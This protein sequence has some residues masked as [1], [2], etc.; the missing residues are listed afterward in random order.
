[1][2]SVNHP[3][4]EIAMRTK[5]CPALLMALGLLIALTAGHEP[6]AGA[7]MTVRQRI[8][9]LVQPYMESQ[10]VVGMTI[11]VWQNDQETFLGYGHLGKDDQRLPDGDTVYEIGSVSKVFTGVLLADAVVREHVRLDQPAGELL[12]PDVAMP[13]HAAR[14]ITLQD[15]STHVSGLPRLPN[16]LKVADPA[17]P[18]A[19]YSAD[20]LFA[21]LKA[22]TVRRAPGERSEYSNVAVGLLGQLLAR[23]QACTYEELLNKR[24]VAPLGMTS[25][26]ITLDAQQTARLATPHR[27][28]GQPTSN[29]DLPA[30]AGAGA[31]RSTPRDMLRFAK[32]NLVPPEGELGEALELAWKV[33]QPIV[34]DRG[35]P[36]GLGWHATRR[37]NLRFHNGETGGYH[38]I[39]LVNRDL[40]AAVV[41]LANTANGEIDALGQDI[42]KTLG[43]AT[44]PPR[45][46]DQPV[47]VAREKMERYVGTYALAPGVNFTV[48]LQDDKLMVG[49]TGQPAYQVFAR[50]PTVWYYKVVP[51]T[52]TFKVDENGKC[53]AVELFQNGVRQTAKRT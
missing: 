5:R 4:R 26:S 13:R 25:T 18:Y 27:R 29:W 52:L 17:N 46:F 44:V 53:T 16:N 11:G 8:D 31:I 45:K 20:D 21:F 50:S 30:L 36:M 47:T 7:D 28:D 9:R 10:V 19:N 32:A 51:A 6:V 41:V 49:L 12:P 43:G 23:Q 35:L 24:I 22:H 2:S 40:Q 34:G 33:H 1:M 39:L 15:L 38:S 37:G 14:A 3:E 48:T 42:M